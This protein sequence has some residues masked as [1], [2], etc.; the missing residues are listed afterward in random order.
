M[1]AA[2]LHVVPTSRCFVA[3]NVQQATLSVIVCFFVVVV[4]FGLLHVP[5]CGVQCARRSYIA[6]AHK[7][8]CKKQAQRW[9]KHIEPARSQNKRIKF[10]NRWIYS[11]HSR[12]Y[13]AADKL[14]PNNFI[15]IIFLFFFSKS[16]K[17]K[18]IG[19]ISECFRTD[20]DKWLLFRISISA[21]V[22][23]FALFWAQ[24]AAV[25]YSLICVAF[26]SYIYM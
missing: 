24:T 21:Y 7:S 14:N 26:I 25:I 10:E 15:I 22:V 12:N 13:L 8:Q 1:C 9:N 19:L 4:G 6:D 2:A 20:C 11:K 3:A 17:R 5:M 18:F 16:W 23:T